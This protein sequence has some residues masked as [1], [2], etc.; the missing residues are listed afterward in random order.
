MIYINLK[1]GACVFVCLC[2]TALNSSLWLW[3]LGLKPRNNRSLTPYH[4]ISFL[5]LFKTGLKKKTRFLESK[6]LIRPTP[7]EG[8]SPTQAS[9]WFIGSNLLKQDCDDTYQV[10]GSSC[11]DSSSPRALAVRVISLCVVLSA[12]VWKPKFL[13]SLSSSPEGVQSLCSV[14]ITSLDIFNSHPT[15]LHIHWSGYQLCVWEHNEASE[16]MS[17]MNKM[18]PTPSISIMSSPRKAVVILGVPRSFSC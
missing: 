18:D 8:L 16:Y 2:W 10:V 15:A 7:P 14:F 5:F 13:L 1:N 9:S 17:Q 12:C 3:F 4:M 11:H 6:T